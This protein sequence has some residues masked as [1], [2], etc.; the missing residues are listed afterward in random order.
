MN[1]KQMWTIVALVLSLVVSATAQGVPL[2]ED[3]E[4][5]GSINSVGLRAD[6]AGQDW[7]EGRWDDPSLVTLDFANI[8]GNST[9]KAAFAA[10][11][12]GNVYLTQEFRQPITQ[13]ATVQ[14]DI[15]VASIL[16][17]SADPDRGAWMLVGDDTGTDPIRIGPNAEDSERL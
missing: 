2:L 13:T 9:A 11:S 4:F 17:L 15:Y 10:S 14:W 7:Y 6:T 1:A 3:S 5:N 16:N 8:G 12:T